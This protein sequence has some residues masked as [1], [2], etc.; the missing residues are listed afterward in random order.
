MKTA[1][2]M[3]ATTSPPSIPQ[4][5]RAHHLIWIWSTTSPQRRLAAQF[6]ERPEQQSLPQAAAATK[7][8]SISPSTASK[9]NYAKYTCRG[10]FPPRRAFFDGL[11]CLRAD[12]RHEKTN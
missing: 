10:Q 6:R 3:A 2:L 4:A 1:D 12:I 9:N 5:V 7:R 8:R 11:W